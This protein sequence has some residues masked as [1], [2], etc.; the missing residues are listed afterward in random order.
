MREEAP[1]PLQ[2]GREHRDDGA[3]RMMQ[4]PTPASTMRGV[5]FKAIVPPPIGGG[6]PRSLQEI[7]ESP[8]E[9]EGATG[10]EGGRGRNATPFSTWP[11]AT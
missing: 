11:E 3:C 4:G 7:G 2:I 9:V 6:I 8:A 10:C 5:I 1:E